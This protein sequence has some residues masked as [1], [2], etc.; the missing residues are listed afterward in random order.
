MAS[1]LGVDWAGGCWVVVKT[2]ETTKIATEPSI[3]N[4]WHEYGADVRSILVDIP[5][6]LPE[7]GVRACDVEAKE[8]L[9][10]RGSTVFS[11][12]SREVVEMDDYDRARELNDESLG[13]QSWWLFPRIREVDVFLQEH[14]EATDKIYE[15]HPEIC[16]AELTGRSLES[17]NSVEGRKERLEVLNDTSDLQETVMELVQEREEEGEWHHRISKGRL[18]D[19]IDAAILAYTA[20]QLTLGPRREEPAYPALP[21]GVSEKDDNLGVSMEIVLPSG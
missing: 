17:K 7:S 10:N 1:Y 5:I 4:V 19:V 18:D 14:P 12:P 15:S 6:G 2:G 11:I 21:T 3:L 16:F 9:T 20:E 13:S 8:R